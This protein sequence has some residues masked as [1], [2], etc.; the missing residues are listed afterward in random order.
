MYSP[1]IAL[2]YNRVLKNLKEIGNPV[3]ANGTTA[4]ALKGPIWGVA[5]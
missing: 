5:A 1:G 4:S 3:R 2:S